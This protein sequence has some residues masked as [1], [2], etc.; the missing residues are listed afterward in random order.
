VNSS[1]PT[2]TPLLPLP[3]FEKEPVAGGR[4]DDSTSQTMESQAIATLEDLEMFVSRLD[5][6]GR[7]A[8]IT[9]AR[10]QSIPDPQESPILYSKV[11]PILDAMCVRPP[12]TVLTQGTFS[13][14]G[15]AVFRL[16]TSPL[17]TG[18]LI[19]YALG[20]ELSD[21]QVDHGKTTSF[22]KELRATQTLR[23]E[24]TWNWEVFFNRYPVGTTPIVHPLYPRLSALQR[25][26]GL[27]YPHFRRSQIDKRIFPH[28]S[29]RGISS[30]SATYLLNRSRVSKYVKVFGNPKTFHRA[31][32]RRNVTSRD[33][34]HHYVRTGSWVKGRVEMKQRWYPSGLLPRTY[35]SWGGLEI[36]SSAYLRNFFNDQAD[37]FPPTHRLNRVQPDWLYDPTSSNDGFLFYDLESFTSWFH[38]QVPFL[39][40]N[41]EAAR[42]VRVYLVGAD[43]TLME[44]D[45][46]DL[47]DSYTD[48]TTDFSEFVIARGLRHG[49]DPG[50]TYRH[51]TAGFLGVPGNLVTCTLAHGL[52]VA[53]FYSSERQMQVPGDD[54]GASKIR[55]E[56]PVDAEAILA[57]ARTLGSLQ[58][59]KIFQT[60][61]LC[62]YL[63]RLVLLLGNQVDLAPMLIFPLLPYLIDPTSRNFRSNRFRLP[64]RERIQSRAAA[65]I[66]SFIRDLW[67]LTKGAIDSETEEIIVVFL[68]RVHDQVGLPYGAIHQGRLYGDDSEDSRH[69]P[70]IS[71]KYSIDD[72]DFFRM[73]PDVVFA[74]RYIV[75]MI[76]RDTNEIVVSPV[77]D[78]LSEGSIIVV[79]NAKVWRFLEDMG[80][81]EI[82]GIPGSKI[83]LI[84]TDAR[85]AFLY[86]SEPAFRT[87]KVVSALSYQ[88]LV[89]VG[90]IRLENEGLYDSDQRALTST[91]PTFDPNLRNWRYRR[92]VDLDNP[93]HSRSSEIIAEHL[94]RLAESRQSSSPDPFIGLDY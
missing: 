91:M 25:V 81:V 26:F 40:A 3:S 39:R 11:R 33:V 83:E 62:L 5:F 82:I 60:P 66:V 38:E 76:I 24:S 64:E 94:G 69:Y 92:Y 29:S 37:I 47:I 72:M 16:L 28:Y 89:S 21:E 7:K 93:L 73:N 85:D 80:Y 77:T 6:S 86:G 22:R 34:I 1:T 9:L 65:V 67:K 84:G 14:E 78:E 46:G 42:G 44:K 70:D 75:R 12:F 51:L 59:D 19:V 35:F 36:A 17:T 58:F 88:Q 13:V 87:V 48:Y 10:S 49:E 71:V 79:K 74:D 90:I 23:R 30:E 43:L 45:L 61:G 20:V 32:D 55:G 8:L 63:K 53:T 68:R 4:R 56:R 15:E 54:V 52:A 2:T 31:L 18:L 27:K 41:A 50:T 57:L